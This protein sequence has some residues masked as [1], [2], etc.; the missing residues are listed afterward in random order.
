MIFALIAC[1]ASSPEQ[2]LCASGSEIPASA[3]PPEWIHVVPIGTWKGHHT[4]PPFA[5]TAK[6]CADIVATAAARKIDIVIDY[7]HQSISA[8]KT[9]S[10]APAAGWIDRL[11]ARNDGVWAHV[12]SWT[13]RAG[14]YLRAREYRYVSPVIEFRHRDPVS[15]EPVGKRLACVALTNIPFFAGEL[16][17]VTARGEPMNLLALLLSTLSLPETTTEE[18]AVDAVKELK[19]KADSAGAMA[20]NAEIGEAVCASL[21]V[22]AA[23]AMAQLDDVL[24]HKGYVPAQQ[25]LDLMAASTIAVADRDIEKLVARA[26]ELGKITPA[27]KPTFLGMAGKDYDAACT[28]LD[29]APIVVGLGT[30]AAGKKLAAKGKLTPAEAAICASM[31]LTE[32]EYIAA[33][34]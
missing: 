1:S 20:A 29:N 27:M 9:G 13:E 6:D 32:D 10:P 21:K 30:T 34:A 31:S 3:E 33:R 11:E 26:L 25:H 23:T 7:E 2:I 15:G 8:Q 24:T 16:P 18:A 17:S 14:Q 28:W 19:A 5:V 4:A 22:D 12:K